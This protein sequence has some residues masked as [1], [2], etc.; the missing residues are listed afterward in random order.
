M[1]YLSNAARPLASILFFSTVL[2]LVG[3]S[4]SNDDGAAVVPP[5][6]PNTPDTAGGALTSAPSAADE[7][8]LE[9]L[10]FNNA[11]GFDVFRETQPRLP[12][13]T[14]PEDTAAQ[15][16]FEA[17]LP[18]A[19]VIV[20]EGFD[21]ALN[22]APFFSNLQNLDVLAGDVVMIRYFPE[23]E[24]GG[25]PGMFEQKLPLGATFTDNF[26]GSKT[27]RWQPLQADV[28]ILRFT[29]VAV[30][31]VEP[32]YRTQQSVLI[33]VSLPSD[34]S[35]I[36]NVAPMLE[37][38]QLDTLRRITVRLGDP[39]VIE[40]RG[41][42]LNGTVPT[43]EI[44]SLPANASFVQHPRFEDVY[45]AKLTPQA[46]GEF[47][48]EVLVR[49]SVDPDLTSLETVRFNVL[50]AESFISNL[51]PLKEV[52]VQRGIDIGF[53]ALQSFYHQPDGAIY[54]DIA[55]REFNIVTPENSMKMEVLNPL[56]GRFEFAATDNLVR[57]A[58][59][60]NMRIHGHPL[61]WHR[62]LPQWITDSPLSDVEQHM[63]EY[64]ER[65]MSRY[66]ADMEVWDIINEPI[67]DNGS[68]LRQTL[69]F[70][71]MGEQFINKALIQ[72]RELAP[73]AQLLINEFDIS[74]AGPKFD[75]LM[76]LVE[77]LQQQNVPLD[78]IGFQMHLFASFN[79]FDELRSN[80]ERVAA[81]G[82]DIYIT[83]LDVSLVAGEQMADALQQ[84]ADVYRQV[85][86]I[87]LEQA[88]C[89]AIQT[90]GITDQYSFRSIF[91]PLPFDRAYQ[92]KPA[93][94]AVHDVLS[95]IGQ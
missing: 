71:A 27:F 41:Q 39:V 61:I 68:G 2:L 37:V 16:E 65:I 63:R 74:M 83:E 89:R 70:D 94:Q 33:R 60:H 31:A 81:L 77:R 95:D 73:T 46:V 11:S 22:T 54:A 35:T 50:D 19:V 18:E 38:Q 47:S 84:Q 62:Q 69:W 56:P 34:P 10:E 86:S 51:V 72:A 17:G 42:D 87:C 23:D 21:T 85:A 49:D 76:A 13:V 67:A 28:G 40:L 44:P 8:A 80:F 59:L 7:P 53:A 55:G 79:T 12:Q 29:V 6:T 32:L 9:P 15:A 1:R 75:A 91:D 82:L 45:V 58:Q 30:D 20:P 3:C 25:L 43:L 36:P 92:R 4:S 24:D 5:E 52:A 14:L 66:A 78:G 90:W 93:F 88:N 57:F 26:D 64:I 48:I